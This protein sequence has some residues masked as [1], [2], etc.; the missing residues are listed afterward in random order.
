MDVFVDFLLDR[1]W[2]LNGNIIFYNG[3]NFN[4]FGRLVFVG[5]GGGCV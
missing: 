4:D 3:S 2:I 1:V 5:G